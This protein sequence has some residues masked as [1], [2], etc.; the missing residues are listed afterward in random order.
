MDPQI[1]SYQGGGITFWNL[2]GHSELLLK[3]I[4]YLSI[5]EK[6]CLHCT[7]S[8]LKRKEKGKKER[9]ERKADSIECRIYVG[10]V[11]L[12][13]SNSLFKFLFR[14]K[15]LFNLLVLQ[16]LLFLTCSLINVNILCVYCYDLLG[17]HK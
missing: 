10:S 16:L 6:D 11:L 1:L 15:V 5:T 4:V 12:V 9:K 17:S 8:S 13:C 3:Q 14:N 2:C 7:C